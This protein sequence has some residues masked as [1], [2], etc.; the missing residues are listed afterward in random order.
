MR[1]KTIQWT[2]KNRAEVSNFLRYGK[3]GRAWGFLPGDILK[4][5]NHFGALY[6]KKGEWLFESN[7]GHLFKSTGDMNETNIPRQ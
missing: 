2:G 6:V 3:R 5:F 1:I 4:T 7:S